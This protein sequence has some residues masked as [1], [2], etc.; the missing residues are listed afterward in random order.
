[1]TLRWWI[2]PRLGHGTV[3]I[4]VMGGMV[5]LNGTTSMPKS[6]PLISQGTICIYI[7]LIVIK[8]KHMKGALSASNDSVY[9]CFFKDA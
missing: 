8:I 4:Y 1:M 2:S 3:Y 7:Q 6:V 5:Y 9:R